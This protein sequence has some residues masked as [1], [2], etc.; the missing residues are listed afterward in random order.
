M[1]LIDWI[2]GTLYFF[3]M[4]VGEYRWSPG[5]VTDASP[6]SVLSGNCT[7]HIHV[8]LMG[9]EDGCLDAMA[10]ESLISIVLLN[11]YLRLVRLVFL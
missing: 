1:G 10:Y 7:K 4:F 11:N 6:F 2:L 3:G 9:W 8:G 5:T